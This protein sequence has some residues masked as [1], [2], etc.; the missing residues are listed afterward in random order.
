[1]RA[2]RSAVAHLERHVDQVNALNVFPVPDGDTGSNMLA[3]VRAALIEAERVPPGQ[4]SLSRVAEAL[5]HG[6]L[7]GAR[8]NSGLILSQVVRGMAEVARNKHRADGVDLG[9]ALTRGAEAAYQAVGHPVEGTILTVAREAAESAT[10]AGLSDSY[11]E[12]VLGSAVDGAQQSVARTPSLLPAL[13][14]AGV[15]D[16][17]GH[18]LFLLLRG[19]LID[20]AEDVE[21]ALDAATL[22]RADFEALHRM[23]G[24]HGGY[25]FETMFVLHRTDEPLQP[26]VIRNDLERIGE[27]VMVAGDAEL[28]NVH[29]HNP[30]PDT[31]IAYATRLGALSQISILNLDEEVRVHEADLAGSTAAAPA[32]IPANVRATAVVAVAPGDGLARAFEAAGA[33]VVRGGAAANPSTEELMRGIRTANGEGIVLLAN[34]KNVVL[35]ARQAA[36]LS[37]DRN[38]AVIE[39]RNAAEGIAAIL[40]VDPH[41]DVVSNTERMRVAVDAVQTLQVTRAVRD[42]RVNGRDVRQGEQ[43]VLDPDEGV[44]ASAEDAAIATLAGIETLRSGWELLTVYVGTGVDANAVDTLTRAISARYPDAAVELVEGGQPHYDF[45]IAAE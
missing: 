43:I 10:A 15:V 31:I 14:E 6:S 35:V 13:R 29:V 36:A 1:L 18:G 28:V 41:A 5:S 30:T 16:S 2:F 44:V 25:G 42:A 45:L 22:P 40:A 3:T 12:S 11:V 32:P 38:V 39:T 9:N 23:P 33:I 37:A 26:A 7:M 20:F 17:G 8:G 27:S 21:L 19:L 34:H 24:H 4:R